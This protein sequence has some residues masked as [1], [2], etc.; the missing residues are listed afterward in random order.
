MGVPAAEFALTPD[1]REPWLA[2]CANDVIHV[3]DS[4]V[5]PPKQ[6]TTINARDCVAWVSF[7]MDGRVSYSSTGEIIDVATKKVIPTL[8]APITP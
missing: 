6:L 4:T 7:S 2:D 1:E 3:F 8:R 5:M